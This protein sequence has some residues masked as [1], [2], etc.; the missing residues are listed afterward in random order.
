ML[1]LVKYTYD[2]CDLIDC[3]NILIEDLVSLQGQFD[4]WA[5]KY[6]KEVNLDTFVNW[7]N[8]YHYGNKNEFKIVERGIYPTAEQLKYP[9][10]C[11]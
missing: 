10:I 2:Y 11:Y 3:P 9:F 5:V 7:L 6:D 8:E 4:K 1:V